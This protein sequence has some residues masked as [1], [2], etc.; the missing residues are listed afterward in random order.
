MLI[1][2]GLLVLVCSLASK[3]GVK[4]VSRLTAA[5]VGVTTPPVPVSVTIQLLGSPIREVIVEEGPFVRVGEGPVLGAW[6]FPI[7]PPGTVGTGAWALVL[8]LD[9]SVEDSTLGP[10]PGLPDLLTFPSTA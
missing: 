1:P 8:G 9:G 10:D 7:P 2:T 4:R 6:G 3:K 5:E